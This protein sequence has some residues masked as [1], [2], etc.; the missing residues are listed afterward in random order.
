M[1][2]PDSATPTPALKPLTIDVRGRRSERGLG[3]LALLALAMT[4]GLL[5]LPAMASALFFMITAMLTTAGLW[6]HG[7]LAGARRLTG[8]SWLADGSWL[9]TEGGGPAICASLSPHSRVGSRWLW[10]RWHTAEG[11]R[12]PQRRS[13]LVLQGDLDDRDLRRLGM[14][15]RLDSVSAGPIGARFA[16]A[17]R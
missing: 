1:S 17:R 6:W 8:I 14:R 7:W 11:A 10:L 12:R 13:M 5:D 3:V 15:L 9:L 2:L 4:T 16:G